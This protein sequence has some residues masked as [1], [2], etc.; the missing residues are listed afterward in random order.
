MKSRRKKMETKLTVEQAKEILC[1][2]VSPP[3]ENY[4]FAKYERKRVN[5]A[6]DMALK[7]LDLLKKEENK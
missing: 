5:A 3:T 7:G 1:L 4:P 6:L 2:F